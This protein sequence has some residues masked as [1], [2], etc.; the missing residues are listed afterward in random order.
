M[1]KR[2]Q[3]CHFRGSLQGH[4]LTFED[5]WQL[6]IVLDRF[7]GFR[8]RP[9]STGRLVYSS[10]PVQASGNF[11]SV[12]VLVSIH[13]PLFA[14]GHFLFAPVCSFRTIINRPHVDFLGYRSPPPS[15]FL[16][17]PAVRHLNRK[18]QPLTYNRHLHLIQLCNSNGKPFFG[19]FSFGVW[20]RDDTRCQGHARSYSVNFRGIWILFCFLFYY[21]EIKKGCKQKRGGERK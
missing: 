15:P 14:R 20:V 3:S 13:L 19:L 8:E 18:S 16:D 9:V 12:S 7:R 21:G 5:H 10:V 2:V 17:S 11:H 6:S 1:P 4:R